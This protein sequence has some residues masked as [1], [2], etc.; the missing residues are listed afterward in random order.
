MCSLVVPQHETGVKL[1]PRI[2]AANTQATR[3]AVQ[4]PRRL[5]VQRNC[6]EAW[7]KGSDI[8]EEKAWTCARM[9][10]TDESQLWT[11][12]EPIRA[13]LGH[14]SKM[15]GAESSFQIHLI[16][17]HFST[18]RK[19]K[20][21][22]KEQ[23]NYLMRTGWLGDRCI[24][25]KDWL[26]IS[27]VIF[28]QVPIRAE[29]FCHFTEHASSSWHVSP[30]NLMLYDENLH[31]IGINIEQFQLESN[32]ESCSVH[33]TAKGPTV[34]VRRND[35]T[36]PRPRLQFAGVGLADVTSCLHSLWIRFSLRFN[37]SSSHPHWGQEKHWTSSSS[38]A[39]K[40]NTFFWPG[41]T[42]E[43]RRQFTARY[44]TGVSVCSARLH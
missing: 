12:R 36:R 9:V 26:L 31:V 21:K 43:L 14:P 39:N 5:H 20:R 22:W 11:L 23:L 38:N 32:L 4:N 7:N 10:L 40:T 8:S 3:E 27:R 42:V 1:A 35:S 29:H 17:L 28:H 2:P 19:D 25:E 13:L 30:L 33:N 24:L 18:D 37:G 15:W 41:V 44:Y 16:R 6:R 34:A